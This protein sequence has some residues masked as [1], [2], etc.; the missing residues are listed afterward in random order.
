MDI[1][2]QGKNRREIVLASL[3][4]MKYLNRGE[5]CK[6]E[7]IHEPS[8]TWVRYIKNTEFSDDA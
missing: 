8:D 2:F 1:I 3:N 5:L 7:P 4:M 6:P